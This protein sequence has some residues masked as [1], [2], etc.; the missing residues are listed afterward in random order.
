MIIKNI[1]IC[2]FRSYYGKVDFE[3]SDGLTLIIGDNGDGK[4]TFFE[5]IEW[6]FDTVGNLPTSDTKY[7]SKKRS[8]E[9]FPEETDFVRVTMSYENNSSSRIFEKSFRFSKTMNGD[10]IPSSPNVKLY[11]QN[12]IENECKEGVMA[13]TLFDRDFAVSIR[14]YCLFK[15]EQEL[16]IFNKEEALS[17]LVETFSQVRDFDPYIKFMALSKGLAEKAT[18]NALKADRTNRKEAE[19]LRNLIQNEESI[20]NEKTAEKLQCE[21]EAVNYKNMLENL[22]QS[23]EASDLLF[24]TNQRINSLKRQK[25]EQEKILLPQ[26]KQFEAKLM[27]ADLSIDS[28]QQYFIYIPHRKEKDFLT[29]IGICPFDDYSYKWDIKEWQGILL[30]PLLEEKEVKD[31][32]DSITLEKINS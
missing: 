31:I 10:I 21:T 11:I 29:F 18:D 13:T 15:G 17:Y 28:R 8:T 27:K 16:N 1:T 12:G 5:A 23:R 14:K 30:K 7:I 25:E 4:T 6:L 32:I 3:I 24:N 20:V 26:L 2:N 19:R 9:L 22:E